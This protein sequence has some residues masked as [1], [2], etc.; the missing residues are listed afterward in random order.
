MYITIHAY[1]W[2]R[3]AATSV[4]RSKNPSLKLTQRHYQLHTL[5]HRSIQR[6]VL[7][8]ELLPQQLQVERC[9]R[10]PWGRGLGRR[11]SISA[12]TWKIRTFASIAVSTSFRRPILSRIHAVRQS[13]PRLHL[14][15]RP[16]TELHICAL[17]R[18]RDPYYKML[19]NIKLIE[20]IMDHCVKWKNW[21]PADED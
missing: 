20:G 17:P 2:L 5:F 1:S 12:V 13:V 4:R 19:V 10:R 18:L 14:Q 3:N 21:L 6:P 9:R 8:P 16:H 7:W 11:R 15:F